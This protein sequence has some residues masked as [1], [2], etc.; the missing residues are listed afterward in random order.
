MPAYGAPMMGQGMPGQMNGMQ[1]PG[2]MN[3]MGG[4]MPGMP[5]HHGRH[6]HVANPD[7]KQVTDADSLIPQYDSCYDLMMATCQLL[8]HRFFNLDQDRSG[9]VWW[10]NFERFLALN[11]C[12]DGCALR[13]AFER[14]DLECD[15]FMTFTEW[16]G[17]CGSHSFM[18][19]LLCLNALEPF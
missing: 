9:V 5:H 12:P 2:Q 11:G 1:M 15:G 18:S 6:H 19:P 3:M 8:E 16:L 10:G 13:L 4:Q 14:N 7:L 17:L